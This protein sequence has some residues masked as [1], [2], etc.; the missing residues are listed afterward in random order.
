MKQR[1]SLQFAAIALCVFAAQA[2]EVILKNGD[3][4][5]GLS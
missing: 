5:S 4:I 2:D 1:Q 3:K